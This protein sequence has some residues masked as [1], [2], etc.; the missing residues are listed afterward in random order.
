MC[1]DCAETRPVEADGG[2]RDTSIIAFAAYELVDGRREGLVQLVEWSHGSGEAN[3][4][5]EER[6]AGVLDLKWSGG[7]GG[8]Q[9]WLASA[10]ADGSV[11]LRRSSEPG[12]AWDRVQLA[13]DDAGILCLSLDWSCRRDGAQQN[14][15][16]A[17]S[18][19]DGAFSLVQVGESDLQSVHEWQAH[20]YPGGAPAEVWITAFDCWHT[21]TVLTGADDG[22]LKAW[23]TRM[24]GMVQTVNRR[25]H[26]AGVCSIQYD[27]NREHVFVTGSY[28]SKVRI[29]DSRNLKQPTQEPYDVEAGPWRVKWHPT[30]P[31][32]LLVACMRSG[33]LILD[34]SAS[35]METAQEHFYRPDNLEAGAWEALAYGADWLPAPEGEF[36]VASASFYDKT[37]R[38]LTTSPVET[39]ETAPP[40]EALETAPV[41]NIEDT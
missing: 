39:A 33:F 2:D 6:A 13:P 24:P 14:S 9:A 26:E 4:V 16:L 7:P 36:A 23:D 38:I 1:A 20:E 32:M 3:V 28:D 8:E 12:Q 30:L 35:D 25:T 10:N 15:S 21:D 22:I 11:G 34:T 41:D 40:A 27:I 18:R 5:W 29:W 19:S 17:V 31:S 37:L